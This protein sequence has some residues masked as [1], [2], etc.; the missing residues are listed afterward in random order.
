MPLVVAV[1]VFQRAT[2]NF[3][4]PHCHAWPDLSKLHSLVA[5]THKDM[6]SNFDA[7][8]D[9]LERHNPA[10]NLLVGSGRLSRWKEVLHNLNHSLAKGRIEVLEDQVRIGLADCAF[11]GVWEIMSKKHIV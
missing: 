1:F 8:L 7:V 5:S 6:M 9:I 3:E 10:A 4:Q 2:P 11:A